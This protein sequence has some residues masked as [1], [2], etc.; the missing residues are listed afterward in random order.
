MTI[1]N[2]RGTKGLPLKAFFKSRGVVAFEL[3]VGHEAWLVKSNPLP[4][5]K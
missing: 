3:N 4:M 2:A 1:S 5:E